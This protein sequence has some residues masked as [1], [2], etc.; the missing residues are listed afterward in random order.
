MKGILCSGLI[1]VDLVF[2]IGEFPAK[3]SKN[4][5]FSSRMIT[6][7]GA[8][9]AASAVASLGGKASLSG[10]IGDDTFGRFL[11]EKFEQRGIDDRLVQVA[12]GATTSRSANMISPDGDRTIVNHRDAGL[13]PAPMVFA[14]DFPFDAALV[15]TR[16]P[17]AALQIVKA[18]RSQGKPVVIDAEAPVSEAMPALKLASHVVFSQQ[19]LADFTGEGAK[20]LEDAARQLGVWCAVTRGALPVLCHDGQHLFEIPVCPVEAVNTLG[21]GD[22]WHAAFTLALAKGKTEI[23]AVYWANAAASLKVARP[24]HNESLPTAEEVGLALASNITLGNSE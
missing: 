14:D 4:K 12:E 6:G 23:D 3:G 18:A 21:A 1:A 15:D 17:Q 22:V 16:W 13:V 5:A 2:E 24:L 9:N 11:R 7:G 10:V 19:G 8:L 20:A